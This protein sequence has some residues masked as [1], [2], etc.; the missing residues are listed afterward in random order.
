MGDVFI[1]Y[2]VA[3]ENMGAAVIHD[4]L[5]RKFGDHVFRDCNSMQAG[6]H[7]P[8]ALRAGLDRADVL[9]V[10]I[11]PKWIS[12]RGE[13]GTRLVD[14]RRD[15]VRWEIEEALARKIIVVPVLLKTGKDDPV[16]PTPDELPASIRDLALHQAYVVGQARLGAD[17]DELAT[18]LVGLV[19]TLVIPRLFTGP[20]QPRTVDSAPSTLLRPE[21]GIVPFTGQAGYLADLRSWA[22]DSAACSA[23][24]VAG[25]GGAGKTR[26]ARMLCDDLTRAGWL[27]GIVHGQAPAADI[28]HTAGIDKPLLVVVDDV[29]TRIDQ[30]VA[31]ATSV[32]ERSVLRDAPARLLLLSR[33]V[34]DWLRPLHN[35]PDRRVKDL[36]KPVNERTT[37]TLGTADRDA[38]FAAARTAFA[39]ALG[40]PTPTGSL[41]S[42]VDG[43]LDVHATAL[44]MVLGG[45]DTG[46]RV[47]PL[48]RLLRLDRS[49][50]RRLARA[51]DA[52]HL[53]PAMLAVVGTVATLCRPA[54]PEQSDGLAARLPAIVGPVDEYVRWLG[55]LYPG[56]FALAAIR[57]EALGE[58]LVAATLV[59]NPALAVAVAQHG[60]D[61]HVGNALTVLGR[62]L[63]R[64]P[65]VATAVTDMVRSDPDRFAV[66]AVRVAHQ[67]PDPEPFA[68]ALGAAIAD[69]Q[70]T[71]NRIWE[72]MDTVA[73]GG[74]SANPLRA[75]T[76]RAFINVF[77][78][79]IAEQAQRTGAA[80]MPPKL[81]EFG[82][83]IV[84]VAL[85]LATGF[86]DP[87]SGTMPKLP[88]GQDFVPPSVADALRHIVIDKDWMAP[89]EKPDDEQ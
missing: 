68:R 19:P 23:R 88:G 71:V 12:L 13:D 52:R 7:Y 46:Q 33:S 38:Q 59:D 2:R 47:D 74:P 85:N 3:E 70:I 21:Y 39:G 28:R 65:S 87:G 17:L 50:F 55:R 79:P 24:L 57:P 35:H 86:L 69:N 51:D 6:E 44:A 25:P 72:L 89:P 41:P 40:R 76:L 54:S 4:T 63:H 34:G 29:E 48:R 49:H 84:D 64:H 37:V 8:D 27:A 56:P 5:L 22:T 10:V 73:A 53:D 66:L 81:Q 83:K 58:Q 67:L 15:W 62:A 82:D 61:E 18:H 20:P 78:K 80:N 26:L 1:N 77:A 43:L 45:E 9:L 31:L 30:L 42:D 11:G 32:G 75:S 36:F 16:M 14:R 60:T